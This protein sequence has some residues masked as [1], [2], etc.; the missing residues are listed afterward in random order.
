MTTKKRMCWREIEY[1]QQGLLIAPIV[2]YPHH[3]RTIPIPLSR[4]VTSIDEAIDYYHSLAEETFKDSIEVTEHLLIQP[5]QFEQLYPHK[6]EHW[7]QVGEVQLS[8]SSRMESFWNLFIHPEFYHVLVVPQSKSRTGKEKFIIDLPFL[9]T[10]SIEDIERY[11]IN[12]N[13]PVDESAK[14]SA[15]YI[16]E[17]V[18]LLNTITKKINYSPG[19]KS[20]KN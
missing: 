20:G 9:R 13:L 17:P 18:I 14:Y 16:P 5:L 7:G 15:F 1:P 6:P 8:T 10:A 11:V 19:Q 12:S 3:K 2:Y 4:L